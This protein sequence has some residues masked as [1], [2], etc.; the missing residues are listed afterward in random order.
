MEQYC[1]YQRYT[2]PL[3]A[4]YFL[5]FISEMDFVADAGES[6]FVSPVYASATSSLA[7][8]SPP[9]ITELALVALIGVNVGLKRWVL[10]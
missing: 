10:S 6:C 2:L 4:Q 8:S 1:S 9:L 3:V 7:N 5:Y